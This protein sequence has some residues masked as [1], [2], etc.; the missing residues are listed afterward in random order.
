MVLLST[1]TVLET[2]ST[3]TVGYD[4]RNGYLLVAREIIEDETVDH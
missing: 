2:K 3:P 4:W 1:L